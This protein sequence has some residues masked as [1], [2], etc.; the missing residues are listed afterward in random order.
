MRVK[1][2]IKQKKPIGLYELIGGS[3]NSELT[4]KSI[5]NFLAQNTL[6]LKTRERVL[7]WKKE[8]EFWEE[9]AKIYHN[10]EKAYPYCNL[11]KTI[12]EFINPK[13]GDVCLDV[14][15]G[16]VK[17]S[18]IIWKKSK[19]K[20][21]KI[22]GIDLVLRPAREALKKMR[23]TITLELRYADIG[24]KLPFPDNCFNVIVANLILSYVIDFE[25][26]RGK[27]AFDSVIREMFGQLPKRMSI[28]SGYLWLQSQIC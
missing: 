17:M 19:K 21:K 28:S 10:L 18:Q 26:K 12:E 7:E 25:E 6:D 1:E 23:D 14:G 3:Q 13:L 9:Y 5:E 16:S 2:K 24:Q 8:L 4:S 15:C 22:I 27:E 20:V 11:S